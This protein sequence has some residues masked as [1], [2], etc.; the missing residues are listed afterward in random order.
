[1]LKGQREEKIIGVKPIATATP[2]EAQDHQTEQC[3]ED[4]TNARL[5]NQKEE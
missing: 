5:L 3:D 1:V 2:T 4:I